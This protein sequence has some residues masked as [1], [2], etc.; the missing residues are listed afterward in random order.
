MKLFLSNITDIKK[1]FD[2]IRVPT[3]EEILTKYKESFRDY[4]EVN[5]LLKRILK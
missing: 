2:S 3:Y 1:V 5:K 4:Y